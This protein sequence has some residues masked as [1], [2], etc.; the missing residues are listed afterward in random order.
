M[1]H[2]SKRTCSYC[3]ESDADRMKV[4]HSGKFVAIWDDDVDIPAIN[5]Y[6]KKGYKIVYFKAGSEPVENCLRD[7][8]MRHLYDD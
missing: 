2:L 6:Q 1:K 7:I 4:N 8:V 5:E 3:P